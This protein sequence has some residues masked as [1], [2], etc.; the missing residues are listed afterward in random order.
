MVGLTGLI[1]GSAA[2]ALGAIPAT[3]GTFTGCYRASGALRVIDASQACRATETRITWSQSGPR[4]D[5]GAAG[6]KGDTGDVG[7]AGPKGDTGDAGPRGDVGLL[8]PRGDPG[9]ST[10]YL[11][12]ERASGRSST[13][14]PLAGGEIPGWGQIEANC[15][16][17]RDEFE[18]LSYTAWVSIRNES[19]ESMSAAGFGAYG[20]NETVSL[21]GETRDR[22]SVVLTRLSFG[23]VGGPPVIVGGGDVTVVRDSDRK[24][25]DFHIVERATEDH[26]EYDISEVIEP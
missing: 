15:Q 17:L 3:D 5:R 10:Q 13:M 7:A 8:G 11:H 25:A 4:G 16:V 21:G 26:C 9:I 23:E 24:L 18:N 2:V 1:V 14:L 19:G 22:G 6:P 12:A 20:Y